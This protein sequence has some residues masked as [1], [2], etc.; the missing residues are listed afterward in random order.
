M[1]RR[2]AVNSAQEIMGLDSAGVRHTV[3]EIVKA[4][5]VD[6]VQNTAVVETLLT[7]RLHIA[8]FTVDGAMV[9]FTA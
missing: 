3:V 9:S 5:H 1:A 8:S 7:Q 2:Q 4:D 6:N